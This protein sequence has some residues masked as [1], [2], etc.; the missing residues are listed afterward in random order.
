M[1]IS[2]CSFKIIIFYQK[3][4]NICNKMRK[5][6]KTT[7]WQNYVLPTILMWQ[8]G[9]SVLWMR[10]QLCASHNTSNASQSLLL[11]FPFSTIA[12][13]EPSVGLCPDCGPPFDDAW[14][15]CY[16]GLHNKINVCG[17]SLNKIQ[18]NRINKEEQY[19][20]ILTNICLHGPLHPEN[21]SVDFLIS[22]LVECKQQQ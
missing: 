3:L 11:L 21:N 17:P 15:M 13:T 22:C 2:Y 7:Q 10:W 8:H 6:L 16:V 5:S 19:L 12:P 1:E 14:S 18:Y 4:S 9:G 20:V